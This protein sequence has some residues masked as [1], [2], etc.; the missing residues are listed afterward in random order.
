MYVD[1]NGEG[2]VM[3]PEEAPVITDIPEDTVDEPIVPTAN[4]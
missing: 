2:R 3:G 4:K 1:E